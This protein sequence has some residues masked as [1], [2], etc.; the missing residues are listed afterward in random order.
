MKREQPSAQHR[1]GLVSAIG[2]DESALVEQVDSYTDH[3][4]FSCRRDR[5]VRQYFFSFCLFMYSGS[6]RP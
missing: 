4:F 1:A 5:R 3:S 2:W 6:H